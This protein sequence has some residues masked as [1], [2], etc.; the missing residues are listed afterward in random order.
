VRLIVGQ[1]YREPLTAESCWRELEDRF[2]PMDFLAAVSPFHFTSYYDRE[3]GVPLFRRWG[4]F[5]RLLAPDRLVSVKELTNELEEG[6]RIDGKRQI[7]LDPGL[8]SAERLVLATGKN[9]S[10][11]IY[12]GKGIFA[13]LTLIFSQGSFQPLPWT[14]PD[15]RDPEAVALFNILRE[16]YLLQLRQ[17]RKAE[18]LLEGVE[19]DEPPGETFHD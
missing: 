14:Y 16:R 11:R 5:Q 1:L 17:E 8:L 2:G 9:Y 13:D 19:P 15:Y 4:T 12:L 3:M 10:H 18:A 7:N 6:R